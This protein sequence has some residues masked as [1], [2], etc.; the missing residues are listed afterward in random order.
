MNIGFTGTRKGMTAYQKDVLDK[1]FWVWSRNEPHEIR[2]HHG[3]CVGADYHAH[4]I[5][6]QYG[7]T[8]VIH[9]PT[10]DKHQ[11]MG[12]VADELRDPKPYLDRNHDIVDESDFLI[13]CP[14]SEVEIR[15]SGTWAT[16]RYA[17]RSGKRLMLIP[18]E[19]GNSL[20]M[21]EGPRVT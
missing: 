6:K 17:R 11:A 5:A 10:N 1:M 7:M 20:P 9:P 3:G 18:P 15:R 8:I 19:G 14:K 4:M 13:A 21:F 2:F 12:A 16:V